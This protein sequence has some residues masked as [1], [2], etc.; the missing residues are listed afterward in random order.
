MSAPQPPLLSVIVPV[1]MGREPYTK[2]L[3]W[4]PA[5]AGRDLEVIVVLDAF[6]HPVSPKFL[7]SINKLESSQLRVMHGSFGSPGKARNFGLA[8]ATGTWV[9]FWDSDDLPDTDAFL[10]MVTRAQSQ[11]FE[12]AV[13]SF[14][15][16]SEQKP[17]EVKT[18]VNPASLDKLISS[19]GRTPGI[20]RFAAKRELITSLFSSLQMAEDQEFLLANKYLSKNVYLNRK[21]L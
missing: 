2:L 18:F 20:W 14:T 10:E 6:A 12:V 17:R 16:H 4:L 7:E 9:A 11:M 5:V 3:S 8:S 21:C 13:G 19:V 15:W 1:A